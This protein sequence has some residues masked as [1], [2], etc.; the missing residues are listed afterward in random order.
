[1]VNLSSFIRYYARHTPNRLAIIYEEERITYAEFA[2]RIEAMAAFLT[3][4]NI[5]PGDVVA[6]FMKNSAAF[7]DIAFAVSHVGAVFLPLNFRLA[8]EE[9]DYISK[10]AEAKIVFADAEFA[11]KTKD[12]TRVIYLDAGAQSN[13]KILGNKNFLIP[14]PVHRTPN[15]LFRIMYTS[16]TT[17]RPK[18]V[19]HS[20]ENFYWKSMEHVIALGITAA[21]KLL[22]IG[23][24]YHVGA[25]DL[26]GIAV[27][28]KG[29]A[30][31]ILRDFEPESALALIETERLSCT[32]GAPVMM[33]QMLGAAE[34]KEWD[35]SS[36]KWWIGGGEKTPESRIRDFTKI[37]PTARY[38]D[39]YGLT[40]SGSGDTLMEAGS[41]IEKIGSVGRPTPHVDIEI[42]DDSGIELPI[43]AEGEIC[44]RGPKVTKGYWKDSKKTKESFFGDWFRT[45]DTGYLDN[46]GFLYITDRKKDLIIS[47]GENI[48]S[49]EVERVIY[50][51]PQVS[52][53]AVIGV[54][55]EQWGER[56]VAVVVLKKGQSLDYLT[57]ENYC[58]KRLAKFKVPKEMHIVDILPRTP[59]GKVL[60]R[61]LRQ[62]YH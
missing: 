3:A 39:A 50:Q 9:V 34:Q 1:M 28:W 11:E 20:Y 26:P 46:D 13:S 58:R 57:L 22:M 24:L 23:P 61:E 56:P 54:P 45:G 12:L 10:N 40:E 17:D 19:M 53:A 49:S 38:I 29:G 62:K 7:L 4:E 59:S 47:G 36:L 60:K 32:W 43:G 30:V 2:E 44:L 33:M 52:A 5:K 14:T 21:D 25:F 41:E 42:R 16:G 31:C 55:D 37:F 48:A 27:L 6:V 8:A 51:L 18:G 15:D 35:V